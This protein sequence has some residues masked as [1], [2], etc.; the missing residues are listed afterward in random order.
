MTKILMFV[1][2]DWFFL[3]HRLPIAKEAHKNG[4]QMNVYA[5]FTK[6]H[7]N[8]KYS[9][10]DFYNSPIKRAT[11][12][13]FSLITELIKTFYLIKKE[14]PSLVH[15][16]TIK[17]IIL[18]GLICFI[19]RIPF[20]ASVSGLG[21]AFNPSSLWERLRLYLIKMLYKIIFL[22]KQS[23]VICQT[24][25]DSLAL[26][27]NGLINRDRV[28]LT[29]GSGINLQDF[30]SNKNDNKSC[31]NVLM[32]SRL[33]KD[34]GVS[35][36]CLSAGEVL[37]KYN[38]NVKFSLAGPI[39]D[40]S[41]SSFKKD[42]IIKM[43][44]HNNISFLGNRDDMHD[45]LAQ[46]DIFV[47]PSYYPEGIPKVLLEAAASSCA[48]ITTDHPG[49]KDAII[50]NKTGILVKPKDVSSLTNAFVALL[51]EEERIKSM[52]ISGRKLAKETF[53]VKNVVDLHYS[54]YKSLTKKT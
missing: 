36:F 12:N 9:N 49:C 4:F 28:H 14:K 11:S 48:V 52:G 35:E 25:H 6:F 43:C 27:D 32:A 38:F 29:I 21:P 2:V 30:Y 22:S 37:K 17:P 23:M 44:A 51:S 10:F 20:I 24:E 34:K 41:P 19:L 45:L 54:L 3:S 8:D 42:E 53:S 15:A 13:P 5:D 7:D 33:L 40:E 46:T 18:L 39:D 50:T 31:W 47:L 1:N 26:V 16:V